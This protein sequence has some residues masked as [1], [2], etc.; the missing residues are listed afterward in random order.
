MRKTITETLN[1]EKD[2]MSNRASRKYPLQPFPLIIGLRRKNHFRNI[3][4]SNYGFLVYYTVFA[5]ADK[6][7]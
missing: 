7:V 5:G 1:S 4:A 3:V 6:N 2:E